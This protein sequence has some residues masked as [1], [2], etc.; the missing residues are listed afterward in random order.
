MPVAARKDPQAIAF[1]RVEIDSIEGAAFRKC[2]GLKS[3][4]EIL[5]YQEGGDN[6]TVRKLIGP[7]KSANLVLTK[8]FV[9]DPSLYQWRDEIASPGG[10]KIARRNGSIV[11]LAADG[12]TEVGRWNFQKAWPVRWEMSDFDSSTGQALCEIL[13]LAVEKLTKG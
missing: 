4:S 2:Q 7:S 6:E 11:A 13:E 3:E 12:K 8:G 9:S 1:F 10:N 5:E